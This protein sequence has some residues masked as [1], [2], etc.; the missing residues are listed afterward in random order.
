MKSLSIPTLAAAVALTMAMPASADTFVFKTSLAGAG[1][2]VPTSL[3]TGMATVTFDD[4]LN[5]VGVTMS[6]SGLANSSPFGHIHCCTAVPGTGSAGVAVAFNAL[7]AATSG[8]YNDTFVLAASA[9]TSLLTG[10]QAGTAYVN[11]HTPGTYAAG[12]IRGF[13]APVPEPATSAL[14]LGGLGVMVWVAKRRRQT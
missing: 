4:A 11:I 6:F 13:L 1:E 14:M 3:A 7:P 12:E 10:T 2:P 9:F 5:S 8:T